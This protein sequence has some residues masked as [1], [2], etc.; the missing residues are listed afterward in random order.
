MLQNIHQTGLFCNMSQILGTPGYTC[1]NCL[2]LLSQNSFEGVE[3]PVLV[4]I[5]GVATE[6]DGALQ[7]GIGSKYL[8]G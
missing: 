3:L 4:K 1:N 8:I 6:I 5:P 2:Q 7:A